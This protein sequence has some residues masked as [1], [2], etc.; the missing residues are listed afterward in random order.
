MGRRQL[1]A[2]VFL[3]MRVC[4]QLTARTLPSLSSGS[5]PGC[6]SCTGPGTTVGS[7][8]SS[9]TASTRISLSTLLSSG[10]LSTTI[11]VARLYMRDG[12]LECTT[13]SS[14]L[15]LLLPWGCLTAPARPPPGRST[16]ASITPRR[17]Q[18]SSTTESSGSGLET[19]FSILFCCSGCH[20]YPCTSG[21]AGRTARQTA[22]WS[23]APP[24]TP[25]W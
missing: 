23:L 10:L 20:S 11:G 13:S 9:S 12:L 4:K 2:L 21:S 3:V 14:P 25:W 19:L 15:L 5:C 6:S 1:L 24:S 7:A 8:R 17:S 16:P 18:S 22:T